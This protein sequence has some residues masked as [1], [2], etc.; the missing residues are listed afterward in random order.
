MTILEP[1]GA[2]F[3]PSDFGSVEN[4]G[5]HLISCI[6]GRQPKFNEVWIF[7][8][9]DVTPEVYPTVCID[10]GDFFGD[11]FSTDYL[12]PTWHRFTMVSRKSING[13]VKWLGIPSFPWNDVPP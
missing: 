7:G 11:Y 12:T 2:I 13:S 8:E 4:D 5:P 10:I 9:D 6:D 1:V 3:Q